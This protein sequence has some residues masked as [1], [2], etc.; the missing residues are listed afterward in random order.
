MTPP[1]GRREALRCVTSRGVSQR[2]ACRHMGWS[3]RVA[4][5]ELKQPGK[6]RELGVRLMATAQE[7]PRFGYRRSAVWIKE[8]ERRV[9]RLWKRLGLNLPRRRPR[10]RRCGT[11]M[12]GLERDSTESRLDLRLRARQTRWQAHDPL[13]LRAR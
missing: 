2:S 11:D 12:R 1:T 4:T 7:F 5:Y 8:S 10:R 3:R 9:K 13:A 6:D